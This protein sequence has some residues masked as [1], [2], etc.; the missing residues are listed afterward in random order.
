[1]ATSGSFNTT[2][3]EVRYLTFSWSLASQST[4]NN[5]SVINWQLKG[6]GSNS[7]YWYYVQN[8]TLVVNGVTVYSLPK[9]QQIKLYGYT[10]LASGQATI[11]H[12]DDGTKTFSASC[13]AG[14]YE[15]DK[16][17]SGSGSWSLTAIPRYANLT[18]FE[19]SAKTETSL[20]FNWATDKSCTA[21]Y[22]DLYDASDN[23]LGSS[24]NIGTGTSGGFTI[25]NLT[26]NT[27]YKV[28][29]RCVANGL[30][31]AGD[32]LSVYTYNYPYASSLPDFVIGN[33]VTIGIFN[34][35]GH[36]VTVEMIA[37]S[38]LVA[39]LT[40]SGGSVTGFNTAA[41]KTVLYNSI[42]NASSAS[43]IIKVTYGEHDPIYTQGGYYSVDQASNAPTIETAAYADVNPTSLAITGDDQDIVQLFST[44]RYTASITTKNG[45]SISG[46]T[47]AVNGQTYSLTVS[48]SSASGGNA[49]ISSGADVSAVF[50]VTD[51]RGL[52]GTKTITVHCLEWVLP[53]AIIELG[54]QN[55]FYTETDIKVDANVAL[56]GSN[57][58]VITYACTK[59]GDSSPTVTG[60]L[61]DNVTS[62][63]LL[64]N[65]YAW[66]IVVTV[67]DSFGGSVSYNA[68][69]SRGMPIIYFDRVKSSVGINCFPQEDFSL[70]IGDE[71]VIING[72]KLVFNQDGSVTWTNA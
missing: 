40:T 15:H 11:N 59:D 17:V 25:S 71:M 53:S 64:D 3:Y 62:V 2:A 29:L 21:V 43:Y 7:G 36:S 18:T 6:A 5:Q 55:N 10:V 58:P 63:I 12:N 4:A 35:L 20:S 1:M 60:S 23:L 56:I 38:N 9:S 61:Q 42:P 67:S 33:A 37:A 27:L 45:S 68:H 48:G 49:S 72:K 24:G 47:V 31:K 52:T 26:V 65:N 69:I 66:D 39:S 46:V 70:E 16:N 19:V 32:K 51:S 30:E 41:A 13:T 34:P 8:V 57:A 44:V 22:W 50:T 54:R 28:R 14:I